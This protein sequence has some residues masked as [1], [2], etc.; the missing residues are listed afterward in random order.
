LEKYN[1]QSLLDNLGNLNKL[2]AGG[3]NGDNKKLKSHPCNRKR[4][5]QTVNEIGA[6]HKSDLMRRLN[7]SWG[8]ICHHLGK[9]EANGELKVV[10][11]PSRTM[12]LPLES[13]PQTQKFAHLGLHPIRISLLET[14]Q[15]KKEISVSWFSQEHGIARRTV[16]HHMSKLYQAEL[17]EQVGRGFTYRLQNDK[18]L[19]APFTE[20]FSARSSFEPE[21]QGQK[22]I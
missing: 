6:I 20:Y 12:I 9:I 5:I 7:C 16:Q 4:I 10:R 19:D 22:I 21:M 3:V 11:T 18:K 14:M 17:V 8:T 15:R 2:D 13:A 1:V